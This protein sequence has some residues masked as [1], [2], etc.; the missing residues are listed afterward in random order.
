MYP[1]SLERVTAVGTDARLEQIAAMDGVRLTDQTG[2]IFDRNPREIWTTSA[3]DWD[4][5]GPNLG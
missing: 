4:G 3:T 1:I 2:E 5:C